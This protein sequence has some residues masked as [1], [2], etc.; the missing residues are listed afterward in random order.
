MHYVYLIESVYDRGQHYVGQ[1]RD[2]TT[3]TGS[4]HPIKNQA[5]RASLKTKLGFAPQ[6]RFAPRGANLANLSRCGAST[7]A[8]GGAGAP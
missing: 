6:L 4:P 7:A 5:P 2:A 3:E 8:K 1:T